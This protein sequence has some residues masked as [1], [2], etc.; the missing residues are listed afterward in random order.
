IVI[1][2]VFSGRLLTRLRNRRLWWDDYTIIAALVLALAEWGLFFASTR[3]GTG[4]HNYYVSPSEQVR[5]QHL[6]FATE[7]LWAPSMMFIK[8]SIACMLL[9][10]KH[11]QAWQ[12]FLWAMI[13]IQV[14]SCFASTV[15]QLLQ[16][17]P[18]AATWDRAKYPDAVCAEPDSAFVSLY[19]NSAIGIATDVILALVPITFIRKMQRPIRDKVVLSCLMGLGIFATVAS[20]VK[21]T[22]VRKYGATG[23]SLWDALG[24]TLWSIIEVQVGI[25]AAC[26]PTLKSP[27]ERTLHRIGIL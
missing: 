3:H 7:I 16:C 10:I 13:G 11:E 23:D 5:A 18:M 24:L 25:F 6:L 26:V 9:R 1:C 20:I 27:F 22:L 14:A 8:I 12:F 15:F 2:F 21:T 4:R 17:I 19:V